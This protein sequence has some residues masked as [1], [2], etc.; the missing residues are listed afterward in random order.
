MKTLSRRVAEIE[1]DAWST[2]SEEDRPKSSRGKKTGER[3]ADRFEPGSRRGAEAPE[4]RARTYRP[5]NHEREEPWG[6]YRRSDRSEPVEI[7]EDLDL[8]APAASRG[9]K[10]AKRT[11][12]DFLELEEDLFVPRGSSKGRGS[13]RDRFH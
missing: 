2:A 10:H 12:E 6:G 3:V 9:K 4:F 5:V 13:T 11:E 1:P 7:E 8:P